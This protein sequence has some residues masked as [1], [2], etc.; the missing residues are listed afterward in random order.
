MPI[1]YEMKYLYDTTVNSISNF[2][3]ELCSAYWFI[4]IEK[5]VL[6]ELIASDFNSSFFMNYE[7]AAMREL[8]KRGYWVKWSENEGKPVLYKESNENYENPDS[9]PIPSGAD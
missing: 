4:N 5:H 6:K 2:S 7:L 1:E 9:K 8:F 3:K